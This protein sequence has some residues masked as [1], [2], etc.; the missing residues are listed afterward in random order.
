MESSSPPQTT[1]K[2]RGRNKETYHIFKT[3]FLPMYNKLQESNQSELHKLNAQ[4]KDTRL[5][6]EMMT[7]QSQLQVMEF[8]SSKHQFAQNIQNLEEKIGILQ[9]EN[10]QL[11]LMNRELK[12]SPEVTSE[13]QIDKGGVIEDEKEEKESNSKLLSE[14]SLVQSLR[15]EV[16]NLKVQLQK[17]TKEKQ[18]LAERISAVQHLVIREDQM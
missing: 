2:H 12:E 13:K 7:Q 5:Q 18:V 9:K 6:L 11:K 3:I 17:V 10:E 14:E 4:L 8:Q 15:E 16:Q 1:T